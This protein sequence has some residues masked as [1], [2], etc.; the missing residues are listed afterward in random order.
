MVFASRICAA[1]SF[2]KESD[3]RIE[4]FWAW[5]MPPL[6]PSEECTF[7]DAE[8]FTAFNG[9]HFQIKSAPRRRRRPGKAR[10]MRSDP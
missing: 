9:G 8:G 7:A 1:E 2:P 4:V 10:L 6:L 5:F 3:D